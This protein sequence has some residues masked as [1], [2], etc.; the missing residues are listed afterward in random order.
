MFGR[1]LSMPLVKLLN[2]SSDPY[3]LA[4]TQRRVQDTA[5]RQ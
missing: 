3:I 1:A 4:L 5:M 2:L